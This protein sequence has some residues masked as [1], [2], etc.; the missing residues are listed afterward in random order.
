MDIDDD[1]VI[2]N[3]QEIIDEVKWCLHQTSP[4]LALR[5]IRDINLPPNC[6]V[7][8]PFAGSGSFYN[9]FPI[10]VNKFKTE[11]REGTDFRDF[12]YVGNNIEYIVTNPPY[13]IKNDNNIEKNAYH[14]ILMFFAV[15]PTVKK[16]VFLSSATCYNSLTRKRTKELNDA[17]MYLEKVTMTEVKKWRNRYYVLHFGRQPVANLTYFPE[18]Y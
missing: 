8:E 17:G 16:I 5:I 2:I 14:D 7:I 15:I 10:N 9:Q 18:N 1:A 12:D 4:E 6:N 3:R 13:A 11:I